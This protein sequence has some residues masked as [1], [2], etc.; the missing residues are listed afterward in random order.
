MFRFEHPMWLWCA[1]VLP[2]LVG[3]YL[4][5][6]Y[7]TSADVKIFGERALYGNGISSTT[8]SPRFLWLGLI[9]GVLLAIAAANP[10]WGYKTVAVQSKSTDIYLLLDISNSML[11]ED[12]APNRLERAK[13]IALDIAEAHKEDRIGLIV[14]AGHAYIQSPLTTDWNAIRL[15]LHAAHPDQA[16]T[17]GTAIGGAVRLLLEQKS[18]EGSGKGAVI[19]LTDGEDHDSDA[20]EAIGDAASAGWATMIIGVGTTTGASIPIKINGML[21]VKRDDQGSPVRTALNTKFM[22]ELAKAGGGRYFEAAKITDL[23]DAIAEELSG[24][25]R[26][27]R[28]L[29]SFSE[30][31]SYYQF[32]LL[33][34]I[35][36]LSLI[37]ALN[38]RF[39]VI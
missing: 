12:I 36:L 23:N 24:L 31:R 6:S 3:L 27:Q 2:L 8:M 13:K 18:T 14:F 26:T 33:P 21:D 16:G 35:I 10:Q 29:R 39:E 20:I 34:A 28:A 37:V 32:F 5:R 22:E 1:L 4:L 30:Y 15:F 11:A 7:L 9:A 19:I 38:F 17:Q 25:E